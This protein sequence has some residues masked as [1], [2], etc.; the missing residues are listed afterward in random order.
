MI[1]EDEGPITKRQRLQ[2]ILAAYKAFVSSPGYGSFQ[3]TFEEDALLKER[4][5]VDLDPVDRASEIESFKLRGD[6]RT[7]QGQIDFF[8][9]AVATLEDEIQQML[10][11]ENPSDENKKKK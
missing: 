7:L 2:A 11:Q 3:K 4:D 9:D 8:E 6:L 1:D 10:S 5:I